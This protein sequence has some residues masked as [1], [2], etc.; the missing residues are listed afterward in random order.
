MHA[1]SHTYTHAYIHTHTHTGG[2]NWRVD[3]T[4]AGE[5]QLNTSRLRH[6][7]NSLKASLTYDRGQLDS[8]QRDVEKLGRQVRVF[9]YVS[10]RVCEC[11]MCTIE[12]RQ[13][14]C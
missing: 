13:T 12:D 7:L 1:D 14:H 9:V 8:L 3:K 6:W 4:G 5:V 2:S 11:T 10:L